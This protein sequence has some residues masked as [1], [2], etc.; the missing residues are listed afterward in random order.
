MKFI[1]EKILSLFDIKLLYIFF[2]LII[3][4]NTILLAMNYSS[5]H[6]FLVSDPTILNYIE[7]YSDKAGILRDRNYPTFNL[8][9]YHPGPNPYMYLLY[10]SWEIN[11]LFGINVMQIFNI[12]LLLFPI[13]ILFIIF[14]FFY[15]AGFEKLLLT[16]LIFATLIPYTYHMSPISMLRPRVDLGTTHLAIL[17]F[18]LLLTVV[19]SIKR[20]DSS[21]ILLLFIS[22]LVMQAHFSLLPIGGIALLYAIYMIIK[23]K[24][25][26]SIYKYILIIMIS[27]GPLF[28]RMYNDP[29]FIFKALESKS[30]NIVRDRFFINNFDVFISYLYSLTPFQMLNCKTQE[31]FNNQEIF[32]I[33]TYST[34]LLFFIYT[35]YITK[36]F[37]RLL[38]L[39]GFLVICYQIYGSNEP[40]HGAFLVGIIYGLLALL[41]SKLYKP[42]LIIFSI[43][44]IIFSYTESKDLLLYKDNEPITV[45]SKEF[46][47]IIKDEK[48]KFNGCVLSYH[49][50]IFCKDINVD[51]LNKTMEF[52]LGDNLGQIFLL[53]L[54]NNG[55]DVCIYPIESNFDTLN[56]LKCSESEYKDENRVDLL[57]LPDRSLIMSN[58]INKYYKIGH[59]ADNTYYNCIKNNKCNFFNTELLSDDI[60]KLD[61]S[62]SLYAYKK[63]ANIKYYDKL[64][65]LNLEKLLDGSY[66]APENNKVYIIEEYYEKE[67]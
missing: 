28:L 32:V 39:A 36:N 63:S 47:K 38:L 58:K 49:N 53:E 29:L 52:Y 64:L 4:G 41:V 30:N 23:S 59:V 65:D 57:A 33:I 44:V 6:S 55:N 66:R 8:Q 48:F 25:R 20:V 1:Y 34:L 35:F 7:S 61:K 16:A 9:S 13:F 24:K 37:V 26:A 40:N 11:K 45:F 31:C 51:D 42:I 18:A 43:I 19:Y 14:Y 46:L 17:T 67:D 10:I 50:N 15:K 5:D 56:N 3:I 12:F 60:E 27:I 21:H 62:S 2:L 22:G 54:L